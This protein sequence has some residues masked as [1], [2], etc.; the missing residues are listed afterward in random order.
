MGSKA[1]DNCP[2]CS[3]DVERIAERHMRQARLALNVW[4]RLLS[5]S[6][7]AAYLSVGSRTV[8]SWIY[9][10]LLTPVPMPGST[11]KDKNGNVIANARARKLAKILIDKADL[12]RLIDERKAGAQ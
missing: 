8:E 1:V 4:P 9:D 12:D 3:H 6:L 2:A 10:G 11:L 5:L 7:T